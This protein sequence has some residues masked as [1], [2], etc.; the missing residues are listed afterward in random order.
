MAKE[1][2]QA[3]EATNSSA[4]P[5]KSEP[6][7]KCTELVSLSEMIRLI[8]RPGPWIEARLQ[9]AKATPTMILDRTPYYAAS[10][11]KAIRTANQ[12]WTARINKAKREGAA[13]GV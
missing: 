11:V 7:E 1:K 10:W 2:Q 12:E 9:E 13:L 4:E 6:A 8:D 3:T 5:T